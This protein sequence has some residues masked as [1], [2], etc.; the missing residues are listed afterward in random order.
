[1]HFRFIGGVP[2]RP[3][4]WVKGEVVKKRRKRGLGRAEG[5]RR[6]KRSKSPRSGRFPFTE[7]AISKRIFSLFSTAARSVYI[8]RYHIC[9]PTTY[10]AIL[11]EP[12]PLRERLISAKY[13]KFSPAALKTCEYQHLKRVCYIT[14]RRR[15]AK[16]L[17]KFFE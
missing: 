6:K 11:L 15:R 16:I 12:K 14:A 17:R 9:E 13:A 8:L 4:G 3:R 1:M 10:R 7:T 5:A 2:I